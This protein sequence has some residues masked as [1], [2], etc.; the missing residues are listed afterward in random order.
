MN[1]ENKNMASLENSQTEQVSGGRKSLFKTP[2]IFKKYC[3]YCREEIDGQVR[4]EIPI[5]VPNK[6]MCNQC[7]EKQKSALG[8]DVANEKWLGIKRHTHSDSPEKQS[9]I[10]TDN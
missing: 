1:N 9:L 7:F 6:M 5:E 3:D 10:L 4:F 8:T 2:K